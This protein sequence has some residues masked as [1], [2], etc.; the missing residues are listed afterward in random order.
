[1]P[2]T[3][4]SMEP[5]QDYIFS[6]MANYEGSSAYQFNI[7][8]S[9]AK[10]TIFANAGASIAVG[11]LNELTLSAT[12]VNNAY[13]VLDMSIFTCEWTCIHTDTT[14][15]KEASDSSQLLDLSSITDCNA[16]ITGRLKPNSY[17]FNVVVTNTKTGSTSQDATPSY[18]TVSKGLIPVAIMDASSLKPGIN[19]TTFYLS[20]FIDR[21]TLGDAPGYRFTWTTQSS[22]NE[23]DYPTLE[24]IQGDEFPLATDL[25]GDYLKFNPGHL[26]PSTTYCFRVEIETFDESG[27]LLA[28]GYSQMLV[29]TRDI[30]SR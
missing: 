6:V 15:C 19:D 4:Y 18:W 17:K 20:A 16:D 21:K 24:M 29:T 8:I 26:L 11:D 28:E 3:A 2:I 25:Y 5:D 14:P 7:T 9:T 13:E 30:P 12:I 22:C 27:E 23:K 10:D 1:M